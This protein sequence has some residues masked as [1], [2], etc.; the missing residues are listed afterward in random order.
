[1]SMKGKF[2]NFFGIEDEEYEIIEEEVEQENKPQR[3]SE[4]KDDKAN[5]VSLK[6]VQKSA[7]MVLF[8]PR[9]F[10]EV[11]DIADHI[12]NRRSVV[13][14]L[15]RVDTQQARQ[16]IDFMSGT[17]YAVSGHIKK[18]GSQTF[19]CTPENIEISGNITEIMEET[20]PEQRW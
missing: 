3:R 16:I 7:K 19:L 15:Q 8:E 4:R 10:N 12:V 11:Q 13:I 2:R 20:D 5:V 6:S 17:V 9:S 18:L 1:M 14:N